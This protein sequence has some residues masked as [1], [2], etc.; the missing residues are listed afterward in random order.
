MVPERFPGH[1][2]V[3][4]LL[5]SRLVNGALTPEQEAF[6]EWLVLL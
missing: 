5:S 6:S 4:P 1:M 2:E 3:D